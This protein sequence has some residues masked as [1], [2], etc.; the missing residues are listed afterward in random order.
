VIEDGDVTPA[1]LAQEGFPPYLL[2]ALDAVT[3]RAGAAGR[4]LTRDTCAAW[5]IV[6]E[7]IVAAPPPHRSG[8]TVFP[9]DPPSCAGGRSLARVLLYV[10][11]TNGD[12]T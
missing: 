3:K 10:G 12:T 11:H 6:A 2:D 8:G 5:T 7:T 9:P 1:Q 4:R